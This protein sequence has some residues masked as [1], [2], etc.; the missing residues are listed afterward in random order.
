MKPVLETERLRLRELT[1]A[2]TVFIQ[3]LTNT[4]GWLKYIG[5]RN[6]TTDEG[7]QLYLAGPIKS[8]AK[9]GFGLWMMELKNERIPIGIGGIIKRDQFN[10]PDIGYAIL[11]QF[12]GKGYTSEIAR[13]VK[14]HALNTLKLP[15]LLGITT[16]DNGISIRI[17]EKI[18][19]VFRED[20]VM[21]GETE[22][23]KLFSVY[24]I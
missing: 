6:T 13:S 23:L 21:P 24:P 20:I 17:L 7:A 1:D 12:E 9:H 10:F 14:E 4:E 2:D 16:Q 18:G 22:V 15:N 11:P 19:M 8:Y 5:N 3:E